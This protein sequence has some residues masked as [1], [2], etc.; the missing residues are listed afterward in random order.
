[1]CLCIYQP[2]V[3]YECVD[4]WSVT[5][6]METI[7]LQF[8]MRTA[9]LYEYRHHVFC[10]VGILYAVLGILQEHNYNDVGG[11]NKNTKVSRCHPQRTQM[12]KHTGGVPHMFIP[13]A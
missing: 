12:A 11:Q 4:S 13:S 1:M 9:P 5:D 10:T 6:M 2:S 8:D 7:L 3:G